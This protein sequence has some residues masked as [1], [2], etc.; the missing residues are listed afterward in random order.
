MF[1]FLLFPVRT[2][3]IINLD[4]IPYSF[5]WI[6]V[7]RLV[8]HRY[9]QLVFSYSFLTSLLEIV[10]LQGKTLVISQSQH[11]T[12]LYLHQFTCS[13]EYVAL[14]TVWMRSRL[15][16]YPSCNNISALACFA[17]SDLLS[18]P[19]SWIIASHS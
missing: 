1:S 5:A 15:V 2:V 11:S 7:V 4:I 19:S 13:I 18:P 14:L 12:A 17:R 16:I 9:R 8:R 10:K 3:P 6:V